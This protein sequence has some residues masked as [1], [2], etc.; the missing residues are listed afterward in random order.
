[1]LEIGAIL[2]NR[3]EIIKPIGQGGM[4]AVYLARD[5]RLSNT[6]A[7]KETFFADAALLAAFEREARLLAGLRHTAL[8]K[9]IDH[10]ADHHGQFLVMEYIPGDDLHDLLEASGGLPPLDEV[11]QW[12]EQLLDALDYLHAQEPPIIHRDIKPQNLKLT[13]RNQIVLL[14][15][16]LA[17]GKS[18]EMTYSDSNS[19]I[20][21]YT[22]CYAPLEQVQGSGTDARSDIYS[23]AATLYHLLTGVKPVDV[24]T[25]ATSVLDG[26]PDPLA[27]A[28]QTNPRVP[29][30]VS[31]VLTQG[32]ALNKNQRI[33]SATQMREM[34]RDAARPVGTDAATSAP[35]PFP[36]TEV[37]TS[38]GP[39][40][41]PGDSTHVFTSAPATSAHASEKTSAYT[42]RAAA[43]NLRRETPARPGERSLYRPAPGTAA[44]RRAATVEM[45]S[46]G[47]SS[48]PKLIAAGVILTVAIAI[49]AFVFTR[50]VNRNDANAAPVN[51]QKNEA[52]TSPQPSDNGTK[53]AVEPSERSDYS[54]QPTAASKPSA[55]AEQRPAADEAKEAEPASATETKPEE[56]RRA[57]TPAMQ[58]PEG[59][60][61]LPRPAEEEARREPARQ[62]QPRRE[63][64]PAREEQPPPH[65][66]PPPHPMPP[67]PGGMPPPGRRR[68]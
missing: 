17:K 32:M 15:F 44:A 8:P 62:E 23:L 22:P 63:E 48:L 14:D 12:A 61:P 25:R 19:S 47:A 29:V 10:F 2:Q 60:K 58:E 7:L 24:L 53:P 38:G 41:L 52:A 67:P 54:V 16:G 13:A 1:M 26:Q 21:G 9:V 30:R 20:F 40:A 34:L 39:T 51:V 3:Y 31:D 42:T 35:S 57:G 50:G 55:S 33:A 45:A 65:M 43:P 37:N 28:H 46:S 66:F 11:L 59:T 4:G 27:S 6:V 68:P 5:Q 64:P 18:V 36:R 56:A 49:I